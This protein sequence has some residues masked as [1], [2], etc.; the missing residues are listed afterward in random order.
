[1]TPSEYVELRR[2]VNPS[3]EIAHGICRILAKLELMD[4]LH[5]PKLCKHLSDKG[6]REYGSTLGRPG[7]G[8]KD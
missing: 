5:Y 3:F 2:K 7:L 4:N 6:K 1:V 8:R